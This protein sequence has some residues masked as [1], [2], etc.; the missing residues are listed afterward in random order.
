[1]YIYRYIYTHT[2]RDRQRETA[3]AREREKARAREKDRERERKSR[4]E[5]KRLT[6]TP[7]P[8]ITSD[9][10]NRNMPIKLKSHF[11][12]TTNAERAPKIANVR[13]HAAQIIM[14]I[15][16]QC[17]SPRAAHWMRRKHN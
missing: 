9:P 1:M 8:S 11:E 14:P 4:A 10:T 13:P 17:C 12:M 16:A 2:E 5:R 3:R 15:F 6:N 7:Q